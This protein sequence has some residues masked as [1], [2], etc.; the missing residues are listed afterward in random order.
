MSSQNYSAPKLPR[1]T[2]FTTKNIVILIGGLVFIGF[3]LSSMLEMQ[4]NTDVRKGIAQLE[5]YGKAVSDF[6]TKYRFIPGDVPLLGVEKYNLADRAGTPGRGDGNTLLEGGSPNAT[7]LDGEIALFW[8]DLHD[9]GLIR[10]NLTAASDAPVTADSSDDVKAYLPESELGEGNFITVYSQTGRNYW[11]ISG[12]KAIR[13]GVYQTED[14]LSPME[15]M[16]ID[17]KLDDGIALTGGVRAYSD[18][19]TPDAPAKPSK[20]GDCIDGDIAETPY[21]MVTKAERLSPGC[22]LRIRMY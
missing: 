22:Q 8:R 13:A 14:A 11:H 12:I 18:I 2:K 21:N 10:D 3:T 20:K 16:E 1:K 9:T 6:R 4:R 5:L 19:A 7:I 17:K 15:A